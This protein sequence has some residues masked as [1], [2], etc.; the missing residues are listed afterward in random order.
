M[1]QFWPSLYKWSM[2]RK[3]AD[4]LGVSYTRTSPDRPTPLQ[5][6]KESS[7]VRDENCAEEN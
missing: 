5:L 3:G 2:C 4:I 1:T 6:P 7:A